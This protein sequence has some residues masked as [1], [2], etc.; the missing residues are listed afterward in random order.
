MSLIIHAGANAI[1]YDELGAVSTPE[2]TD[3]HIP[4]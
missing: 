1:S 4:V 2:G 3:T